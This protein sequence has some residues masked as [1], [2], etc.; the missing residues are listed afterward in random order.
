MK[1]IVLI[2]VMCV[3]SLIFAKAQIADTL[4]SENTET[5]INDTVKHEVLGDKPSVTKDGDTT[6]IRLG[7][8]GITIIERGGKTTVNIDKNDGSKD[9]EK[10]ESSE[11]YRGDKSEPDE[12]PWKKDHPKHFE[13]HFGGVELFLNNY[14]NAK[15]SLSLVG[16]DKFMDLNTSNS[17]GVNVNI[18]EYGIPITNHMGFV[19]GFGVCFNSYYFGNQNNMKKNDSTGFIESKSLPDGVNT[20]DKTKFRDT[21]LNVPLLYEI[22]IPSGHKRPF[23]FSA[24]IIGGLKIR[25]ST[26][27]IYHQSGKEIT[28]I[29]HD[30]LNLSPFRYGLQA[31]VGFSFINIFATY[32]PT[33]L[34]EKDKGP[35]LYPIEVGLTLLSF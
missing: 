17:I 23:Y 22:Q 24:G 9:E 6:R 1:K 5:F 18:L 13:P 8:K 27:E 16:S 7:K 30:D 35:E 34:F 4:K 21:Y 12:K 2:T 19:T 20:Y 14:V 28:I 25:S 11:D 31:R 26:K 29:S 10:Y 33:S 32:Y 15:R 3:G